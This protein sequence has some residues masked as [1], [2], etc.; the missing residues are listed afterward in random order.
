ML[1]NLKNIVDIVIYFINWL[2]FLNIE[3]TPDLNIYL[4]I[5]VIAFIFVLIVLKKLLEFLG[6]LNGERNDSN[7]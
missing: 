7:D 2:F 1:E 3:I 4:G 5:L 6:I